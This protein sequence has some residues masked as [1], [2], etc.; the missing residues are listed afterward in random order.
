[1]KKIALIAILFLLCS[2]KV[3]KRGIVVIQYNAEFNK[4]NSV[5][6]LK[7]ISDAKIIDAWIEDPEAKEYGRVRSVP[8]IVLYKDGE[9]IKR[10]EAGISLKLKVSHRDIQEEVDK[11][12]G[13]NKF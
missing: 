2:F 4:S 7:K 12:T 6:N 3:S 1:M 11:L 9:E 5:E 10:W 13:A 8:T